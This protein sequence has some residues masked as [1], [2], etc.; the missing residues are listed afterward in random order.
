MYVRVLYIKKWPKAFD[1]EVNQTQEHLIPAI[2]NIDSTVKG[3]FTLTLEAEQ[4]WTTL[5]MA[6]FFIECIQISYLNIMRYYCILTCFN[7]HC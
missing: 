7:I 6:C 1:T 2:Q 4:L 5:K 3:S